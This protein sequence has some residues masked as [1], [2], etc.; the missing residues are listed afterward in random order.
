MAAPAKRQCTRPRIGVLCVQGGFEEHLVM[1]KRVGAEPVDVREA[2]QLDGLDGLILPGGEST[3]IGLVSSGSGLLE[4]V[5]K[6]IR[7]GRPVYGTCAGLIVLC[8]EV[9]GQ[10]RGG[11]S[12]IGG[13]NC[14]CTRNG[15][16]R[17]VCSFEE[18]VDLADGVKM[19]RLPAGDEVFIRA[20]AISKV[21]EGVKV[22]A[23]VR[24]SLVSSKADLD[25]IVAVRQGNILATSFHPELT[26]DTAWH[27]YFR[28]MVEE[29]QSK[30]ERIAA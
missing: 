6:F 9:E 28:S 5:R 23:T 25:V 10:Q 8:N 18:K 12:L 14:T 22:I 24:H 21:G 13:L 2:Q 4:G 15:F 30:I 3:T 11:Q 16:G 7:D 27:F 29:V 26:T 19:P 1:V 17:Q 20:P